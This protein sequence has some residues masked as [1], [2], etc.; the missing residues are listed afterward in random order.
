MVLNQKKTKAGGKNELEMITVQ[1][2][3][4]DR[5]VLISLNIFTL[6]SHINSIEQL[7]GHSAINFG[8]PPCSI[9][10]MRLKSDDITGSPFLNYDYMFKN[11]K[12]KSYHT[13]AGL[14]TGHRSWER[15]LITI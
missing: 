15:S 6:Q 13:K 10:D 12:I 9:S 4:D 1:I 5:N 3:K 7:K 8:L 2:V 11:H 14:Q